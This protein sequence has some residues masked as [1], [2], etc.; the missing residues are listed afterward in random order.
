MSDQSRP[1]FDAYVQAVLSNAG[2]YPGRDAS[3][4]VEVWLAEQTPLPGV[5]APSPAALAFLKEFGGLT[6]TPFG[7]GRNNPWE[8]AFTF[9][10]SPDR[11]DWNICPDFNDMY[12]YTVFPI[13]F[14]HDARRNLL[15]DETGRV[16]WTHWSQDFDLG[17]GDQAI[18][19]LAYCRTGPMVVPA[20]AQQ[21]P[22]STDAPVADDDD[23]PGTT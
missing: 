21:T 1:R 6:L 14:H 19:T 2:W 3:A 22:R 17:P 9:I 23:S 15:M 5:A 12:G 8:S 4:P 7:P 16:F 11:V 13:G 20:S 10:P 18:T